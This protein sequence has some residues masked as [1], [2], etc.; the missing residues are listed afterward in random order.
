VK[1]GLSYVYH[2]RK[3]AENGIDTTPLDI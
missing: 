3:V 1:K 2:K